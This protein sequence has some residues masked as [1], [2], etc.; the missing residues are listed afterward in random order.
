MFFTTWM[1]SNEKHRAEQL[2][3][4]G[5]IV[6]G[7]TDSRGSCYMNDIAAFVESIEAARFVCSCMDA[8]RGETG[9]ACY[10]PNGRS[11]VN[12]EPLTETLFNVIARA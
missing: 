1:T 7:R 9:F 4:E 10:F 11:I 3:K 8:E 6:I 5:F 12:G 2:L